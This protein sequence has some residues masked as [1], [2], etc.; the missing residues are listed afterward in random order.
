MT[1]HVRVCYFNAT[2]GLFDG[3]VKKTVLFFPPRL[4][5]LAE[6]KQE[7]IRASHPSEL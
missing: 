3:G 1:Q 2:T 4:R 5:K 6:R 7:T